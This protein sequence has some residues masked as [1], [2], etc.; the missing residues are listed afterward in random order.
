MIGYSAEEI[1]KELML[2]DEEVGLEIELGNLPSEAVRFEILLAGGSVFFINN[3]TP[4]QAS[5]DIDT[6]RVDSAI[7]GI[8][9]RHGLFNNRV[10]TFED[11]LP[12]CYEDRLQE[13]PLKTKHVRY[14]SPS[15][16]DLA[17][18]K[19]Y[20][21]R[22]TDVD[23]LRNPVF[24]GRLD[25]DLLERL[26]YEEAPLSRAADAD[27]D[28]RYQEMAATY[29]HYKNHCREMGYVQAS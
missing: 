22:D 29:E 23:D 15:N 3:M 6:M 19:L 1:R 12:Y 28:R 20:A 11:Q 26:V 27:K 7:K 9:S 2:V 18:M 25:W 5:M 13:L 24:A 16:E 4:R 14:L 10:L 8:V 21:W 17:V